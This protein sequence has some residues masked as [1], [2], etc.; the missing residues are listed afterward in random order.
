M[1]G[2]KKFIKKVTLVRRKILLTHYPAPHTLAPEE[3]EKDMHAGDQQ[4]LLSKVRP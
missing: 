2:Y 4:L 1:N 3:E